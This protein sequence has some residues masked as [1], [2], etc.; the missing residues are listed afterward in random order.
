MIVEPDPGW[1]DLFEQYKAKLA[2][3]LGP[4][5]LR[6]D[7]VGSTAVPGLPAKP[8]IDIQVSVR[9]V[10]DES[11]YR[12]AIES[13]GWPLRAREPDHRFFRPPASEERSVHVHVC[14]AGSEWERE[15]LLFVAFLRAHPEQAAGYGRL[16]RELARRFGRDRE[17]TRTRRATPLWRS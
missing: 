13:V 15:H 10:T 12:P 6:I 2:Y 1:T 17:G 5:A 16:K 3:A 11:G 4:V 14:S 9:D 8:V 7:H